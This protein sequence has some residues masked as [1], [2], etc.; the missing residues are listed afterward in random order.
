LDRKGAQAALIAV[1]ADWSIAPAKRWMT[2]IRQ[3]GGGFC[4]SAPQHVGPPE[5]FLGRLRAMAA[6]APVALGLDCPIGLP[7]A[8]AA[9]HMREP[10]FP[11]F[12]RGLPAGAPFWEVA[13]TLDEIFPGRPFY[14]LR[15]VRGMTRLG[16]AQALGLPDATALCRLCDLATPERPAG[17]PPFWTLGANQSGKAAIAAWRD[18]LGPAMRDVKPPKLWPFDGA[19]R[20]LLRPG[21]VVVAETYPA[22]AMRHLGLAPRGSKRRQADRAAYAPALRAAMGALSVGPDAG[23]LAAL[24]A[25]FGTD[26]TG[27]DR[28]DSFLGALCVL[29]VA[30]G[31]R[32]DFVPAD[33][34]VRRWEGWV[35][36]QSSLPARKTS[37]FS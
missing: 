24:V 21:D 9:L 20:D 5:T 32:E 22:E 19:F 30:T 33:P 6:G 36:G 26:A 3:E 14:P 12:L 27:E 13:A 37:D 10:D 1:H 28:F 34:W 2:V 16:H 25:G 18:F 4:V 17:A 15:G 11:A 35:L 31:Q 23:A 8:Y 7:R 29:A